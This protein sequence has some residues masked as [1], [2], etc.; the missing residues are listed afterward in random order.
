VCERKDC[1]T[2]DDERTENFIQ[3]PKNLI[4]E[5]IL[6]NRRATHPT[7]TSQWVQSRKR[8]DTR[9]SN[10]EIMSSIRRP[11][12]KIYEPYELEKMFIRSYPVVFPDADGIETFPATG[13]P[14]LKNRDGI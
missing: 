3:R 13:P 2:K 12:F 4:R 5:F 10:P 11:G 8:V 1:A 9:V 7:G 14:L 6:D